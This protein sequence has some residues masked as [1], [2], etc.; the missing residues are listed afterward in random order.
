MRVHASS[1]LTRFAIEPLSFARAEEE[2]ATVGIWTSIGH[3]ECASTSMFEHKVFVLKLRSIN[4][5]ASS[6]I[7]S[8]C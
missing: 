7:V 4:G 3:R 1:Q 8:L 5:F 2:L 6:P